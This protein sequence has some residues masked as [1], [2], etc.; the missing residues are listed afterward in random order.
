[1]TYGAD[2]AAERIAARIEE[3]IGEQPDDI[4]QTIVDRF[5]LIGNE[6][7]DVASYKYTGSGVVLDALFYPLE[8]GA[9]EVVDDGFELSSAGDKVI[10]PGP[11]IYRAYGHVS[12]DNSVGGGPA[13]V[14]VVIAVYDP[15]ISVLEGAKALLEVEDGGSSSAH[16][17][18]IVELTGEEELALAARDNATTGNA[19]PSFGDCVFNIERIR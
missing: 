4:R 6:I 17:S 3:V 5:T 15:N 16:V 8:L 14:E 2:K 18:V 12:V 11:G 9:G 1:M 10:V 7:S 19:S 13:D